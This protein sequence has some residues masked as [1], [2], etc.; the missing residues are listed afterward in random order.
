MAYRINLNSDSQRITAAT[1]DSSCTPRDRHLNKYTGV[2]TNNAWDNIVNGDST[3]GDTALVLVINANTSSSSR[4]GY[5]EIMYNINGTE[6]SAI[7]HLVQAGS[8]SGPVTQSKKLYL[9]VGA[10]PSWATQG[11][12]DLYF[13]GGDPTDDQLRQLPTAAGTASFSDGTTDADGR[14]YICDY[15]VSNNGGVCTYIDDSLTS[16]GLW[17]NYIDGGSWN[18]TDFIANDFYWVVVV[19]RGSGRQVHRLDNRVQFDSNSV[20]CNDFIMRT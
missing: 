15:R 1:I 13:V 7:L 19:G 2:T 8:G 4:Q 11:T 16:T 12:Y 9:M 10:L 14:I 3:P 18:T 6:C 5:G 20:T 17:I